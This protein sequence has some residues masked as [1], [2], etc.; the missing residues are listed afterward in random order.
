MGIASVDFYGD[1][2]INSISDNQISTDDESTDSSAFG[3][4]AA[5]FQASMD[6]LNDKEKE[7]SQ[8]DLGLLGEIDNLDYTLAET[9]D[10][11][12]MYGLDAVPYRDNDE[13]SDIGIMSSSSDDISSIPITNAAEGEIEDFISDDGE[14]GD[15][16]GVTIIQ[17]GNKDFLRRALYDKMSKKLEVFKQDEAIKYPMAK[18][19]IRVEKEYAKKTYRTRPI[20][21]LKKKLTEIEKAELEK[22]IKD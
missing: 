7:A 16:N 17:A 18:G 9:A 13:V 11:W 15:E 20:L 1:A 6:G 3:G 10:I 5:F 22:K 8:F 19:T 4:G 12:N 14:D 21:R 2:Q